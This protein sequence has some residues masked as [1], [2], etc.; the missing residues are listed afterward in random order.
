[1][2]PGAVTSKV[3]AANYTGQ[4]YLWNDFS[5]VAPYNFQYENYPNDVQRICFK[6][7]DKRY[8]AV[9]FTVADE[10]KSKRHEELS[11]THTSGW[12]VVSVDVAVSYQ[13]NI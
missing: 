3:L 11:E 7:D 1:M 2:T 10:V 8:F 6:F 4:V 9:R 5:F 13:S 12:S